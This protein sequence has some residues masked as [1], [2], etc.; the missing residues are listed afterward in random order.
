MQ[1]HVNLLPVCFLATATTA[2]CSSVAVVTVVVT[3][4]VV[5]SLAL[6]PFQVW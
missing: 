4:T 1:Q 6:L 2:V 3:V 5:N